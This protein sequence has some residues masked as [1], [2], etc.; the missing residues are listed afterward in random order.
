MVSP[1][2]VMHSKG[3]LRDWRRRGE[4]QH[5]THTQVDRREAAAGQGQAEGQ[6]CSGSRTGLANPCQECGHGA[7]KLPAGPTPPN[8]HKQHSGG[9][10]V[11]E[12]WGRALAWPTCLDP[13]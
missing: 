7:P 1:G 12:V 10:G 2:R 5:H 9:L 6:V 11:R 13:A 8:T 3:P 4:K